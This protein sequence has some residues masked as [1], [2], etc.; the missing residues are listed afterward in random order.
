MRNYKTVQE[1]RNAEFTKYDFEKNYSTGIII[2]AGIGFILSILVL[3]I[4][5]TPILAKLFIATFATLGGAFYAHENYFVEIAAGKIA[6]VID[7][8]GD[9]VFY[10]D[11]GKFFTWFGYYRVDTQQNSTIDT[12]KLPFE[13]AQDID[14]VEVSGLGVIKIALVDSLLL[15][16]VAGSDVI[17]TLGERVL[18]I[19]ERNIA[20][21]TFIDIKNTSIKQDLANT[22]MDALRDEMKQYG[23]WI[24]DVNIEKPVLSDQSMQKASQLKQEEVLKGAG[25]TKALELFQDRL[26]L[27]ILSKIARFTVRTDYEYLADAK[28]TGLTN[29][30]HI[31]AKA[32]SLAKIEAKKN[33]SIDDKFL[34]QVEDKIKSDVEAFEGIVTKTRQEIT[35]FKNSN[36]TPLYG[37]NK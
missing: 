19:L 17:E 33:S 28:S 12:I 6:N 8:R 24:F 15:S 10:I 4:F 37:V 16:R 36:A 11:E 26:N 18:D 5:D 30:S 21:R 29:Q 32:L 3:I 2:G 7:Y 14:S 31:I 23:Y 35:G 34:S 25:K 20:S 1:A 27:S 9:L 13:K 22:E